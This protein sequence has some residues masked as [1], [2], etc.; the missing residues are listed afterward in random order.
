MSGVVG[1]RATKRS[2]AWGALRVILVAAAA[3]G[4]VRYADGSTWTADLTR[5]T[6]GASG[7]GVVAVTDAEVMCPGAELTGITGARNVSTSPV[8]AAAVPPADL[9]LS[10]TGSASG[11]GKVTLGPQSGKATVSSTA[12]AIAT[13]SPPAGSAVRVHATGGLAPGLVASQLSV[14]TLDT[15]RGLVTASCGVPASDLWLIAGG[16]QPGRQERLVLTNAGANEVIV[17]V[18][19]MGADGP[20]TSA[21]GHGLIVPA[22]GRLGVLVDAIAG[23]EKSPVVHVT[24]TGGLVR[25]TLNDTWLDG[26]VPAGSSDVTAAAM[27]ARRA[28]IPGVAVDGS[29]VLRL[30]NPGTT[31]AVVQV[32]T[33]SADGGAPL[34]DKGVFTLAAGSVADVPLTG[35]PTANF[36][37]D[38]SAD[39]PVVAGAVINRR[40]GGGNGDFAWTSATAPIVD[41]GGAALP[42]GPSGL[43]RRL[44]LVATG[45]SSSVRLT[46][47][48]PDGAAKTTTLT[49]GQDTNES[50]DLLQAASVWIEPDGPGAV[51]GAVVSTLG[52]GADQQVSVLPVASAMISATRSGITIRP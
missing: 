14:A 11:S 49:L 48:T 47:V 22:H 12:R 16:G 37:L 23:A 32:R 3:V 29:G 13:T 5:A 27:P 24:A 39:V 19:V 26:T 28:V 7:S 30:A 2:L 50:V 33:I 35:L 45:G 10:A 8:I 52:Q 17:D 20:V 34:P 44:M 9:L 15:V 36:A 4:M 43:T 42:A 41:L 31:E 51:R 21:A 1:G 6:T 40:V 25:A 38:V 46:T 18:S